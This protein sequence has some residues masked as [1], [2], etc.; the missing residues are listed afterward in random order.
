[1]ASIIQ[2]LRR[3]TLALAKTLLPTA[4]PIL[5]A[6]SLSRTALC[7]NTATEVTGPLKPTRT[8]LTAPLAN[9]RQAAEYVNLEETAKHKFIPK[10]RGLIKD[11]KSFL[12]SIGRE[13]GPYAEK[14]KDWNHL[15]T[16]SSKEMQNDLGI[17]CAQRKYI[18]SWREYFRRGI[19]TYEV[20]LPKRQKKYLKVKAK[21]QLDRLKRQGLA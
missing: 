10:P 21:V 3:T 14:F 15:F 1:M 19:D 7:K 2:T 13:C 9:W 17:K 18:L 16:A 5:P 12:E 4:R 6:R 11:P 20:P 8:S